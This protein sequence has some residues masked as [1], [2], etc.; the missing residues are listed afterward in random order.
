MSDRRHLYFIPVLFILHLLTGCHEEPL[1]INYE[2]GVF[3]DSVIT[4]DGLNTQF[5]DYN[6]DIEASRLNSSLPVIFSS[7]RQSS[8]GEFNLTQGM[9]WYMF[10]QT[11]GMFQINGEMTSDPFLDKLISVFNT[12][13]NEFGPFRFFNGYNGLEYMSAA[14]HTATSGLDIVYTRYIPVFSTLP[15]IPDPIPATVFNSNSD[16]AYLCLSTTPDTAYFCS[17]RSGNFDIF[18][19]VRPSSDGI[20]EWFSSLPAAA[21]AVD[22]INSTYDDKCP[23][24][25][26]RHMVFASEMPGGSGGFDLYYSVFRN[27]KWSSP[28]NL[29][30]EINSPANEYRPVLGI[31][32]KY[33]NRFIIFSSDRS[34]GKGGYDIYFTGVTLPSK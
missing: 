18:M 16:D 12:T 23:F 29:G 19:M 13:G 2:M 24:V 15:A 21:S 8:G 20:D 28:V 31:D 27:G 14:T 25:R 6:M 33:E 10:G 3:P 17:D 32:L 30:P 7:N 9:I 22:S 26:G 1:K 5:D 11:T 4:L 34:G